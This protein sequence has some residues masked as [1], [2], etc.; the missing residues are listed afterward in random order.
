M[1][2]VIWHEVFQHW[3][4][5]VFVWDLVLVQQYGP[6]RKFT[7]ISIPLGF[8]YQC[9]FPHREVYLTFASPGDPSRLLGKC[10]SGFYG[11]TYLCCIPVYLKHCVCPPRVDSP[12]SSAMWSSWMQPSLA[13]KAKWWVFFFFSWCQNLYLEGLFLFGNT[14]V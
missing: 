12:H 3:N 4:L 5:Q 9:P 14:P 7:Q 8:H 2:L 6:L 13:F 11:Y 10:S 1:F